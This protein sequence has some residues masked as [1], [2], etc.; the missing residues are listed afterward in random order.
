VF[1]DCAVLCC[2]VRFCAVLCCAV[3]CCAVLCCAVLCCAMR[4]W[5]RKQ[6]KAYQAK[7]SF[8][9]P[10]PPFPPAHTHIHTHVR[11]RNTG[12]VLLLGTRLVFC[13]LLGT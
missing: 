9:V 1:K 8:E 11:V 12:Y 13:R 7:E 5:V 2:A 4:G 6:K 10:L 3:L